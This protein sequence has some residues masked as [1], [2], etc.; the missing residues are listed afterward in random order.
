MQGKNLKKQ[1]NSNTVN[2]DLLFGIDIIDVLDRKDMDE[3]IKLSKNINNNCIDDDNDI[4]FELYKNNLLTSKRLKFIMEDCNN[5]LK[6][7]SNLIKRLIKDCRIPLLDIIFNILNFFD[8]NFIL[9]LLIHYQQRKALSI[10]DLNQQISNEKFKILDS[11]K[12]STNTVGK[13]LINECHKENFNIDI[14]K[15]LIEHGVKI[16]KKDE[17]DKTPLFYACSNGNVT[18]VK[19]LVKHGAK[20]DCIGP[21][22]ETPLFKACEI[23]NEA[24]V[25]FL[26]EHGANVNKTNNANYTPLFYAC[27]SGN[28]TIVKY[29]VEKGASIDT[30]SDRGKTPLFFACESGR[31]EVVKYLVELGVN[32]NKTDVNSVTPLIIACSC[33]NNEVIKYLLDQGADIDVHSTFNC[34][35]LSVLFNNG[36]ITMLKYL[37][38]IGY[39]IDF[40]DPHHELTITPEH[41]DSLIKHHRQF[42]LNE[43]NLM[44]VLVKNNRTDVFDT[45]FS[46][47]EFYDNEFILQLLF[48]YKNKIA[49]STSNLKQQMSNEKFKISIKNKPSN[50]YHKYSKNYIEKYLINEC[51]KKGCQYKYNIL[52]IETWY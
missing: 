43:T 21:S 25:T 14:T 29:L 9:Q 15:F 51:E 8:S 22:S 41:I 10:S 36:N 27:S 24:I 38:Q 20:V 5:Y 37:M 26:V 40:T 31:M 32:I 45:I 1:K 19:C 50:Y 48:C 7:S 33:G 42:I 23:G 6:I 11:F 28:L 35:P 17:S 39:T 12:Y 2:G 44:K 3:I 52:F 16:N 4:I 34:S 46:H 30:S 18:L 49:T 13:Y 47:L